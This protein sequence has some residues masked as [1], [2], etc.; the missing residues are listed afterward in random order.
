MPKRKSISC[1]F[2]VLTASGLLGQP[3]PNAAD[4][5]WTLETAVRHDE[6]VETETLG[7]RL[8]D[9]ESD[10]LEFSLARDWDLGA[11]GSLETKLYRRERSFEF[12]LPDNES[13]LDLFST[14][15]E[16]TYFNRLDGSWTGIGSL[17]LGW[18]RFDDDSFESDSLGFKTM[19]AVLWSHSENLQF[20]FGA[21]YD[22]LALSGERLEPVVGINWSP[23]PDWQL[24]VG[25]PETGVF[26]QVNDSLRVGLELSA[27][28]E[29]YQRDLLTEDGYQSVTLEYTDLR[30]GLLFEYQITENYRVA[31][32][33]DTSGYR[34]FERSDAT[35]E[36]ET[37]GIS[38]GGAT[39]S[40][41]AN[42]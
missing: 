1:L 6:A 26:Y 21:F 12:D 5:R 38:G 13:A 41:T 42:F 11:A 16:L 19:A 37:D 10:S 24:S 18:H 35:F 40:F 7:A 22:S 17:D 33:L 27:A 20:L 39:L 14:G 30:A 2:A 25:F 8:P 31:F 4:T 9:M 36:V 34:E 15:I 29:N 32:S 23:A 3:M 28:F